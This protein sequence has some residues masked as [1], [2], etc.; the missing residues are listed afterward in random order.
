MEVSLIQIVP[1][2]FYFLIP[3]LFP[4]SSQD[5]PI[6]ISM[7]PIALHFLPHIVLAGGSTSMYII[8]KGWGQRGKYDKECFY[9]G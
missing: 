6:M 8:C 9:F 4:S 1:I 5:V 7:F 3:I 2:L